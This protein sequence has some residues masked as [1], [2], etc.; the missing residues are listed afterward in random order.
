MKLTFVFALLAVAGTAFAD[1]NAERLARGLGPMKPRHFGQTQTATQAAPSSHPPVA[2]DPNA[3]AAQ[4]NAA[5]AQHNAAVA[6][7][8]AAAQK[9]AE[10]QRAAAAAAQRNAAA[11]NAHTV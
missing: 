2:H 7:Q 8:R 4:H 5:V 3:A 6:A 11:H 1:T 10:S 9:A